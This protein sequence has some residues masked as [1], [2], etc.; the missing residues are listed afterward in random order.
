[1]ELQA[2][3]CKGKPARIPRVNFA[4]LEAS[5]ETKTLPASLP[6]KT[7]RHEL[8]KLRI[9]T[10]RQHP[11]KSGWIKL[12]ASQI[13]AWH[14]KAHRLVYSEDCSATVSVRAFSFLGDQIFDRR[15]PRAALQ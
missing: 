10:K 14:F 13:G 7:A 11:R 9:E 8:S 5:H 12:V 2:C 15:T 3:R 4:S 1:M 6:T